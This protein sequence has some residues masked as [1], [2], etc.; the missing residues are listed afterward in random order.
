MVHFD[1]LLFIIY[2]FT[3]HDES[4]SSHRQQKTEN[5]DEHLNGKE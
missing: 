2:G 5:V 3:H 4:S 1:L